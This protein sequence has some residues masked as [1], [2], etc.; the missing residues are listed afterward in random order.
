MIYGN[1]F[2]FMRLRIAI[3]RISCKG[4]EGAVSAVISFVRSLDIEDLEKALEAMLYVEDSLLASKSPGES[5]RPTVEQHAQSQ[6]SIQ[7]DPL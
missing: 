4:K 2:V 3:N 6:R 5:Q 1:I 7:A